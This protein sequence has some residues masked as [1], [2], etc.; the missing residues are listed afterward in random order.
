M[1]EP[2]GLGAKKRHRSTR[3][4]IQ[5]R[6][7][8]LQ[9]RLGQRPPAGSEK[10][11]IEALSEKE[12]LPRQTVYD[13]LNALDLL[14]SDWLELLK[15]ERGRKGSTDI[16]AA[17]LEGGEPRLL[18]SVAQMEPG[19]RLYLQSGLLDKELIAVLRFQGVEVKE[20]LLS[21]VLGFNPQETDVFVAA[22][23][24]DSELERRMH[25]YGSTLI[26]LYGSKPVNRPQTPTALATLIRA[27]R[28]F[29]GLLRLEGMTVDEVLGLASLDLAA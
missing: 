16:S 8:R 25:N 4:E 7:A 29:D 17:G 28:Q 23:Q 20:F 6:R 18:V 1:E 5:A 12:G 9:A 27:A 3:E 14:G 10:W 21:D 24:P 13:D 26:N 19:L 11:T 15:K 22:I 2:E